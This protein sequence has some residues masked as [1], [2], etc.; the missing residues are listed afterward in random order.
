M[1]KDCSGA[2][3]PLFICVVD[4]F[5]TAHGQNH[6]PERLE[7]KPDN[8]HG[9]IEPCSSCLPVARHPDQYCSENGESI[10]SFLSVLP[11]LVT[12]HGLLYA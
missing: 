3:L 10:L 5:V 4:T 9:C 1:L 12:L 7:G 2:T 6:R 11:G 8:L